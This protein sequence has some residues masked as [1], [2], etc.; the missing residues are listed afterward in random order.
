M[1]STSR[2]TSENFPFIAVGRFLASNAQRSPGCGLQSLPSDR[3]PA[4]QTHPENIF[5]SADQRGSK[6]TEEVMEPAESVRVEFAIS[7]VPDFLQHV[8]DFLDIDVSHH[9]AVI[10]ALGRFVWLRQSTAR[11]VIAAAW[12]PS[13]VPLEPSHPPLTLLCGLGLP[14]T[15]TP[16][17]RFQGLGRQCR[18]VPSFGRSH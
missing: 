2:T 5:R 18:L 1:A 7:G 12:P 13:L 17:V 10:H 14:N 4:A 11:R 3:P 8:I 16:A 6:V 9:V 15:N